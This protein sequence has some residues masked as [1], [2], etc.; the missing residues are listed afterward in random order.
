MEAMIRNSQTAKSR[1]FSIFSV[2][3]SIFAQF[4]QIGVGWVRGREYVGWE[5]IEPILKAKL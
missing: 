1:Q 5:R 3:P 2:K 4:Q